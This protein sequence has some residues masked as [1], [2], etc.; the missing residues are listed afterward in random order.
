MTREFDISPMLLPVEARQV[1]HVTGSCVPTRTK[2]SADLIKKL[3]KH[4]DLL[5]HTKDFSGCENTKYRASFFNDEFINCKLCLRRQCLG[6]D[7]PC[8]F[9][10]DNFIQLPS[11]KYIGAYFEPDAIEF[12]MKR[13]KG[14]E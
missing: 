13:A 5:E 9:C 14:W 4:D 3:E 10:H 11:G 12:Q 6:S 1:R 8:T 2:V 7:N